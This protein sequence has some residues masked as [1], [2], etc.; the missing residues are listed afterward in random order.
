MA[1]HV[2]VSDAL[3]LQTDVADHISV[4]PEMSFAVRGRCNT[5]RLRSASAEA[6]DRDIVVQPFNQYRQCPHRNEHAFGKM[7]ARV[8]LPTYHRNERFESQGNRYMVGLVGGSARSRI[9]FANLALESHLG[10]V[11]GNHLARSRRN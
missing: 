5:R 9:S 7:L 11:A 4:T 2:G 1:L 10:E 3:V 6:I 8:C